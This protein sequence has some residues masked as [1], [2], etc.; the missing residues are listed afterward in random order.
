MAQSAI[1]PPF[2]GQFDGGFLEIAGKLLQLAFEAFEQRDRVGRGAREAGDDLVIV[3]AA[4]LAR[5]VLHHV[6]AHGH[7]AIGDEHDLVVLA[8]AQHRCAVHLRASPA[9]WHPTII[10]PRCGSAKI[11]WKKWRELVRQ[12]AVSATNRAMKSRRTLL[13]KRTTLTARFRGR[14]EPCS[15]R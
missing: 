1:L 14:K 12:I 6:I 9:V 2:L 3:E 8:H 13:S 7:L 5:G 15:C 11:A 10:A 4:R